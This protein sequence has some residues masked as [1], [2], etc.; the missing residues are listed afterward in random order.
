MSTP[1]RHP[2]PP[3]L[4]RALTGLALTAGVGWLALRAAPIAWIETTW[5]HGL[6]PPSSRWTAPLIDAVPFSWTVVALIALPVV[7]V[8]LSRRRRLPWLP[9]LA[10]FV[11]LGAFGFE[12][13][14]GVAY[15]RVPLEERLGLTSVAP[16]PR[17]LLA[18]FDA[19]A[20]IARDAAPVD[21]N[22]VDVAAG[23]PA[24]PVWTSASRCVARADAI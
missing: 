1:T 12:L 23:W 17:E 21:P 5:L 16:G 19:L 4:R 8:V 22:R 3:R 11:A 2:P 7:L 24:A 15:R 13:A 10:A 9:L 14:W 18:A 6:L 20:A